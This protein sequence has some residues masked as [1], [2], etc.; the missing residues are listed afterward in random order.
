MSKFVLRR[1]DA[2]L[3]KRTFVDI[4]D[5]RRFFLEIAYF[6]EAYHGWQI[7][8]NAISVQEFMPSNCMHISMQPLW[9]FYKKLIVLFIRSMH[10]CPLM[11]P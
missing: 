10:Y 5:K 1:N 4:M 7:Q 11:W 8:N 6:G 2:H 3:E 9:V